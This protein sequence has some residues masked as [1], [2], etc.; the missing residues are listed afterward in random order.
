MPERYLSEVLQ[1]FPDIAHHAA[2]LASIE[3]RIYDSLWRAI[4]QGQLKPGTK[5]KELILCETFG[6]SRTVVRKVLVIMEQEGIVE[7]PVNR[8]AYVATPT[9]QDAREVCEAL[10]A[11][12]TH[13]VIAL[14]TPCR[15]LDAADIRRLQR[16]VE[17]QAEADT[18]DDI[19]RIRMLSSEFHL[20]LVNIHGNKILATLYGNLITRLIMATLHYQTIPN[21][22]KRA[23]FQKGLVQAI[24]SHEQRKAAAAITEFYHAVERG[25]LLENS[26]AEP[27]LRAILLTESETPYQPSQPSA[28]NGK[29]KRPK[30]S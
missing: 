30:L 24:I 29:H 20:L 8:G 23:D 7:L 26:D 13:V 15:E 14:S 18:G 21:L 3:K 25:L 11:I 5:L 6:V 16:Q 4:I 9:P 28:Q 17:I 2:P 19:H 1:T 12:G 22:P 10:R 27:D